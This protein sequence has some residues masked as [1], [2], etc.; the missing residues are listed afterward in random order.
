[1]VR[2]YT[3]FGAQYTA[4][5]LAPSGFRLPLPGLPAD[6]ATEL[7]A[8]LCSGG[9]LTRSDHPLGNIIEF[10]PPLGRFPTIRASL[11]TTTGLLSSNHFIFDNLAFGVYKYTHE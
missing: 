1:M 3:F 11:S 10:R 5:A 7:V 6:F 8:N 2:N 9:T 4:C